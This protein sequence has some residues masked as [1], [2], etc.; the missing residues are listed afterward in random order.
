MS[1]MRQNTANGPPPCSTKPVNSG[2]AG[3][4]VPEGRGVL[5]REGLLQDLGG[6]EGLLY[7]PIFMYCLCLLCDF[8]LIYYYCYSGFSKAFRWLFYGFSMAFLWRF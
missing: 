5:H 1:K 2:G 8:M 7:Q 6:R 4:A 3:P